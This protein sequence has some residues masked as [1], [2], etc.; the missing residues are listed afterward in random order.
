MA[1]NPVGVQRLGNSSFFVR[2]I[3]GIMPANVSQNRRTFSFQDFQVQV[4]HVNTTI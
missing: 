3:K 4:S 2:L 1:F